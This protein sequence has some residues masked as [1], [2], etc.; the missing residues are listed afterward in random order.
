VALQQ[1]LTLAEG[2]MAQLEALAQAA[3]QK[4]LHLQQQAQDWISRLPADRENRVSTV[5]SIQPDNMPADRL[6]ALQSAFDYV[7][8]VR[9]SLA[10]NHL[11]A[12][13][14]ADIARRGANAS[15]G[16]KA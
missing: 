14:L 12:A 10:D 5:L 6:A 4:A 7:G 15:A 16:L 9:Q 13:E 8:G 11:S 2:T 1:G 3:E